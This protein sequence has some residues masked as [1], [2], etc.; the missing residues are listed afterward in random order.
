MLEMCCKGLENSNI[1]I[2]Q[3]L[4]TISL[5]GC[6]GSVL[7]VEVTTEHNKHAERSTQISGNIDAEMGEF[8]EHTR[9]RMHANI[10]GRL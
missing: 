4:L 2:A 9:Q 6:A 3:L 10:S 5:V 7:S 8:N 1:A